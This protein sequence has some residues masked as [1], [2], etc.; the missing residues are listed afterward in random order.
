MHQSAQN[1]LWIRSYWLEVS[2]INE[3]NKAGTVCARKT[4]NP[5]QVLDTERQQNRQL[6]QD[7]PRW[8][9]RAV[10]VSF[11]LLF[12]YVKINKSVILQSLVS[13]FKV[14]L[15]LQCGAQGADLMS[16]ISAPWTDPPPPLHV[17]LCGSRE[18]IRK[19]PHSQTESKATL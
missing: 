2:K 8:E 10:R 11:L 19:K 12:F 16:C 1:W 17:A 6:L 13:V 15:V 18:R 14:L 9:S 3:H 4:P 5:D 7:K